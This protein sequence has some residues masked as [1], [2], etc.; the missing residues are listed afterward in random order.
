VGGRR[1]IE[2]LA[3]KHIA[4]DGKALRGCAGQPV[5]LIS[6][7]VS[8]AQLVF[9]QTAVD[10]KSN[11]ITAIPTLLELLDIHGA[12]V[13]IGCYGLPKSHCQTH[14]ILI[15]SQRYYIIWAMKKMIT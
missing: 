8:K 4:L 15:F 3:G 5:Y 7:F 11:E 12:T 10:V 6:A 2:P 14:C 9:G 1:V 13:T